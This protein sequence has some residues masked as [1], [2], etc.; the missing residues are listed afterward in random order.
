MH[1][2]KG[3]VHKLPPQ[4]RK[5]SAR[6]SLTLAANLSSLSLARPVSVDRDS[7]TEAQ[8]EHPVPAQAAPAAPATRQGAYLVGGHRVWLP[9]GVVWAAK[10]AA[11]EHRRWSNSGAAVGVGGRG[12]A[13]TGRIFH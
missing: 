7:H 8:Q 12:S 6:G 9:V 2:V 1:Y 11:A 13:Q 4:T 10:E 5:V 3:A